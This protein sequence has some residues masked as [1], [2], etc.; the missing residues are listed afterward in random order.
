VLYHR[1]PTDSGMQS[2]SPQGDDVRESIVLICGLHNGNQLVLSANNKGMFHS[3]ACRDCG[4]DSTPG[5][6]DLLL[7]ICHMLLLWVA[8][9][10]G[11]CASNSIQLLSIGHES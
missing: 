8:G 2:V 9:V 3:L 7:N 6:K 5:V 11:V 4:F 10:V 1:Y